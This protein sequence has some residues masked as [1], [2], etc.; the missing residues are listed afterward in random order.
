MKNN[1]SPEKSIVIFGAGKIGRS[2]VGQLF[3]RS[4]YKVIFIDVDQRIINELNHRKKYT[5]VIK[6]AKDEMLEVTNVSGIYANDMESVIRAIADC[7]LMA[8][9]VGKNALPKIL[10]LISQGL[11]K[12][13]TERPHFPLDIILAENIRD[14]C[15]LVK[16]GLKI[17]LDK[18]FPLDTYVGLIETS[19]GKMVP[20]MP[21]EKEEKDPLLVFAEPYNTLILDKNGFK[22][23]I[24]NVFGLSP[25]ENI[26]A[27][28]DRKAFIHNL[29]HA[30]AAYFGY[31]K[32]PNRKYLNEVLDDPEICSFVQEAMCQSALALTAEYPGIFTFQ[33]LNEHIEE[34]ICRFRNKALGDTV[35]RIGSD[36]KR[37]L[38]ENDRVV[39]AINLAR[40]HKCDYDKLIDVLAFGLLF[41]A[42]DESEAMF[43]EDLEFIKRLETDVKSVLETDC[44]FGSQAYKGLVSRIIKKYRSLREL[45][46]ATLTS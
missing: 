14:A 40:I 13:F 30:A 15:T 17:L 29:G 5:V 39:G 1:L 44:G 34:L 26:K 31:F 2:F 22:N 6:S 19:I 41:R 37:K 27:W 25:K 16:E 23:A 33:D 38:S 28:V 8:T 45:S 7:S 10:P 12:R 4:G 24:P 20:I 18:G 42:K 9:C 46:L 36:L 21:K 32:F 11:E 3:S 35:F 43:W